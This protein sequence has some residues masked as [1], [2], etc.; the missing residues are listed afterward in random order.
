MKIIIHRVNKIKELKKI[1]AKYGV[2]IDIRSYGKKLVLNHEPAN[3][4]DELKNYLKN[5][6]NSILIAN[7]KE[8]GIENKVLKL[9]KKYRIK[10]YFLLDVEFPFIYNASN[11]GEKNISIRFSEKESV[12]T[13][14]NFINKVNYVWI[15]TFTK[16]PI[17]KNNLKILDKFHKCL[18]SPDRW[19]RPQDI[20]KYKKIIFNQK[21]K[22][23]SVMTSKKY[24]G[25]GK[26]FNSQYIDILHLTPYEKNLKKFLLIL[27][28]FIN[29]FLILLPSWSILK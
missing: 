1:P 10:K 29:S 28:C 21:I 6:N 11:K 18:V 20:K 27:K 24:I 25:S 23:D 12:E 8:A 9:I 7:I 22:I 2:E 26:K 15:D 13:V 16:F 14:K 4:G 5:F 19:N 17:N 3:N